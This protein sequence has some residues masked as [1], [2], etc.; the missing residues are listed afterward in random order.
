MLP[1]FARRLREDIAP[2]LSSFSLSL[3]V[4]SSSLVAASSS[5]TFPTIFYIVAFSLLFSFS[6][7]IFVLGVAAAGFGHILQRSKIFSNISDSLKEVATKDF[8]MKALDPHHSLPPLPPF[9]SHDPT[10]PP[11]PPISFSPGSCH[12]LPATASL[13]H[14][15]TNT[16]LLPP[17]CHTLL[18]A[19]SLPLPPCHHVLTTILP[20]PPAPCHPLPATTSLPPSPFHR[21]HATTT[22]V[23]RPPYCHLPATPSIAPPQLPMQVNVSIIHSPSA[24]HTH[25]ALMPSFRERSWRRF[26]GCK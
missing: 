24:E 23:A 4:F 20:P 16:F 12:N 25:H 11:L 22:S 18:A 17:H 10:L 15:P 13:L 8:C 7:F 5:L 3:Y 21:P 2:I 26:L 1:L 14:L 9:P 6:W 19:T